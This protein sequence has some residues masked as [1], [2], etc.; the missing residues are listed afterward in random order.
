M[1]EATD[2]GNRQRRRVLILGGGFAGIGAAAQAEGRRRRRRAGRPA[3]LPH[4]PAAPVPGRDRPAR[5]RRGRASAARP[6]PRP[7]ER[8]RPPGHRDRA[9]TSSSARCSSRRW[10]RSRYD[11]L[12]LGA[13]RAASTSSAPRARPSTP[14]RCTRSPTRCGSRST[15]SSSWEAADRDPALI[16]DGALNVVVVGGGPTGVESAGALAE[17]YR[18]NFA[19]DY[20]GIPQ[21]QA[22]LTLVEAGPELFSMFKPDIRALHGEGARE[23]RRRGP[24][25]ARSSPR[26]APTRVTLKSGTSIDAHTLVWGAGLQANPIV[27]L[28]RRRARSAATASRVGPDL[29]VA[30]HPE[31]FAVGDI[32]WITDADDRARCSRSSARS[33]CSRASRR[34]RTSPGCSRARRRSRSSYHDKGTMATIGRGAA[35]VQF[36]RGRTMK[37]KSASL[38]WGAVHLALL[39]TGEDRA[40]AVVDWTWAGFTHERPGRITVDVAEPTRMPRAPLSRGERRRHD[41]T[42][43]HERTMSATASRRERPER[44]TGRQPADVLVVFGIT[45]DLA[46]VMTFRSLYRLEQRGLLDCPIVG[47]AVDDWTVDH[48]RERARDSI[49]GTGEQLDPRVF[50]RL[51]ARLSY[52]QATSTTSSTYDR[53]ADAIKGAEHPV[54]YLEIPPFLFGTVVE[55]LCRGRPHEERPDRGREAVRP[56]PRVGPGARRRAAPVRR[57]VAALPHRPLPRQDGA[58]GDPLPALREHDARAG[59]EPQLRRVRP[60]HD[61]RGASASRTAATSTTRSARCATSSSTT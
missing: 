25:R 57:R 44:A 30:G 28:A 13:R 39:S 19:K 27:A 14:S 49:V 43:R 4:L 6:V 61:G 21:E 51:A 10:R 22:H 31:V 2:H 15:S 12:V 1:S 55:G 40:K 60:D 33:R 48:L 17:L 24:R 37:G 56:R 47:V 11:Y 35:V 16:D 5:A 32:A 18:S 58:R 53:V 20:P 42:R 50:D 41:E 29:S 38:A 45:G 36:A 59:L 9:S 3:R 8:H 46:K 54:F 52:V 34:A 23:A 7:A 26:V